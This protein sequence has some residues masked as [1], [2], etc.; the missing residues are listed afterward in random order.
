M[1]RASRDIVSTTLTQLFPIIITKGRRTQDM[2]NR[3]AYKWHTASLAFISAVCWASVCWE[4]GA[5]SVCPLSGVQGFYTQPHHIRD[6]G[7][8]DP[9]YG[10][11]D[12]GHAFGWVLYRPS[13]PASA[14]MQVFLGVLDQLVTSDLWSI[15]Q[16]W[17]KCDFAD[18]FVSE[19]ARAAISRP[20]RSLWS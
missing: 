10:R 12:I 15:T 6:L 16:K 19:Q 9:P 20:E 7:S 2:S 14:I 18:N 17:P 13:V 11:S 5:V 3:G 1:Y 4:S 8:R